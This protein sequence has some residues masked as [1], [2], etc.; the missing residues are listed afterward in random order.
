MSSV[1]E[2]TLTI[3]ADGTLYAKAGEIRSPGPAQHAL[4]GTGTALCSKRQQ[5]DVEHRTVDPGS[6]YA[7]VPGTLQRAIGRAFFRASLANVIEEASGHTLLRLRLIFPGQCSPLD[8]QP[9][10]GVFIWA[11]AELLPGYAS[12]SCVFLRFGRLGLGS[13]R[14]L[15]ACR[16]A[17]AGP[18]R[19]YPS[20]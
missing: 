11:G 10:L 15:P 8:S 20:R 1:L 3:Q 2:Y 6:G 13:K 17:L 12:P 9:A 19:S 7:P 16:F 4:C 18:F 14:I 5:R